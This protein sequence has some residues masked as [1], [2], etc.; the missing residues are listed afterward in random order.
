[1]I[2]KNFTVD[3]TNS[4]VLADGTRMIVN[5]TGTPARTLLGNDIEIDLTLAEL[6]AAKGGY[7]DG[8]RV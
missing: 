4:S 5:E 7:L 8:C 2:L 6:K 3:Y 1:M